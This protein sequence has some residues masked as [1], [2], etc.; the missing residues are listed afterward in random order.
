[1]LFVS[2][3]FSIYMPTSREETT[4]RH[5]QHRVA[6]NGGSTAASAPN[7]SEFA[8]RSQSRKRE[9]S[10]GNE[11]YSWRAGRITAVIRRV[12]RY[13]QAGPVSDRGSVLSGRGSAKSEKRGALFA[14]RSR[15]SQRDSKK[16][17]KRSSGRIAIANK[18]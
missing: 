5:C 8:D 4:S 10:I 18:S 13:G 3:R 12:Y 1:M 9:D 2:E 17:N 6:R 7:R 16:A 14:P 11:P 15:Q